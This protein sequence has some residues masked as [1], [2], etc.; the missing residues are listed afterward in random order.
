MLF[1]GLAQ[2]IPFNTGFDIQYLFFILALVILVLIIVGANKYNEQK[3]NG[4]KIRKK[5]T[6]RSGSVFVQTRQFRKELH[7]VTKRCGFDAN[8]AD[9]FAQLC[10]KYRISN[11]LYLLRNEKMLDEVFS[12]AFQSLK[13][14]ETTAKETELSKT[15]LFRIRE[16]IDNYRKSVTLINSTRSIESGLEVLLTTP[17]EEQYPIVI[18]E[19]TAQGIMFRIPRDGFGNEIRLPIRTKVGL[20]FTTETDQS[21]TC[22]SRI[23]RYESGSRETYG[24]IAHSDSLTALPNRKHDRLEFELSCTFQ[25]VKVANI[26]NGKQTVHKFYPEG[27]G[28]SGIILDISAG[29]CS[30]QTPHPPAQN[31]YIQIQC[32]LNA[33]SS[34]TMTG[35]IIN[36][37]DA[38]RGTGSLMHIKFAKMPRA[39]MNRIFSLI[40]NFGDA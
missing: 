38:S 15:I 10:N 30:M 20:F 34:D 8:Q 9:F 4:A 3:K 16:S 25:Q 18:V 27:R 26:I 37:N 40:F 17:Q 31:T 28:Y 1:L 14:T 22:T 35:K 32:S 33:K 7:E 6:I 36:I 2:V 13:A 29:G 12:Q 21:Y 23:V 5:S 19:N 24:I 11:P 39:T